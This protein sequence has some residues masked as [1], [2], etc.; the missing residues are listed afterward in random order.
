M[1]KLLLAIIILGM[2]LT[3]SC[4]KEQLEEKGFQVNEISVD[5]NGEKVTGLN[6]D[7]LNFETRPRNVLLTNSP[8]HR[9][10]PIYKLNFQ[11]KTN[12]PFT[13]SNAFYYNY[14][15]EDDLEGANWNGNFMPGFSAMYGYNLINISHFNVETKMANPFF[16]KPVLIKTLY[17]P[18]FSNDTL[19]SLPV[20]RNFYMISV[21]DEDTNKDGFINSQDLRHFYHFNIEGA[22]IKALIPSNYSVM[23]SEYDA[24]LD[25][26][27]IFAKLDENK[28]GQMEEVEAVHI[29]WIDLNDPSQTG[30]LYQ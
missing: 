12:I 24:A 23:N 30:I 20:H 2:P 7:T 16:E 17:Y 1:S 19:N 6:I 8:S 28:N 18:A 25:Y 3:K 14:W 9:L 15:A 26:M 22:E 29:F 10:T 5:E 27:Y 4:S 11:K 21:Y 13:G